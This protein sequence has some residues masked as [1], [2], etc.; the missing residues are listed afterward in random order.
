MAKNNKA[1][2]FP[3]FLTDALNKRIAEKSLRVLKTDYPHIDFSSN[4][5]LGFSTQGY[6]FNELKTLPSSTKT[7]STG[8]RLISGNSILFQVYYN[9]RQLYQ[10][11]NIN[12][13]SIKKI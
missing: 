2:L 11:N 6:L 1:I 9:H 4:D 3:T 7:G 8:S 12:T 13:L 10:L 5:Y